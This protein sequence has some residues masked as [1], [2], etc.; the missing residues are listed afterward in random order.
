[1]NKK[2]VSS[3]TLVPLL[4]CG[5]GAAVAQDEE[6]PPYVAPVDTFTCYYNDGKGPKD[7]DKVV[8]AWNARLDKDGV[9]SYAAL[10]VTPNYYGKGT[11]EIG[12]LGWWTSQEAMGAGMDS[13]R[14]G[15]AGEFDAKFNEVLSCDTHSHYASVQVKAPPEGEMPDNLVLMFSNCT[16]D[17]EV[18]WDDLWDRIGKGVDYMESQGYKQGA[19]LMWPVFGGEGTPD[20]DFTWVSVYENYT[21]F[22]KAYQHNANGGG[23]QAMNEIMQNGLECDAARV[24][25]AK[26]IRKITAEMDE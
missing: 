26:V 12:W 10:L 25:D 7:L 15:A 17:D 24:Y 8:A 21:D 16:R 1:M 14:A 22:G 4:L 5:W 20:W 23:R 19:F 13:Y 2:V 9:D 6:P 3:I 18:K 11:F